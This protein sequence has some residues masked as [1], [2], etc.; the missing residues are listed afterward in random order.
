MIR[1]GCCVLAFVFFASEAIGAEW[2]PWP[3]PQGSPLVAAGFNHD[4]GGTLL[5][6]CD[7]KQRLMSIMFNEPR[8]TWKEGDRIEVTTRAD[9]GSQMKPSAGIVIAPTRIVVKDES[10]WDLYTMGKARSFFAT[11]VGGYA[12]V[13]PLANFKKTTGPVLQAC[14]DHW[15]D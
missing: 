8:A 15:P 9:D 7:T 3:S 1:I 4:D 2:E 5:V 6:I 12:R 14:G 11:G 10:T 13:W